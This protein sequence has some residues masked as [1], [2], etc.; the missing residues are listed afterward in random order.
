MH[1]RRK[2]LYIDVNL[3]VKISYLC[4]NSQGASMP[5]FFFLLFLTLYNRFF[6]GFFILFF[7]P[8]M[9]AMELA[10]KHR[11]NTHLQWKSVGEMHC[12]PDVRTVDACEGRTRLWLWL[13]RARL[14]ASGFM[15]LP[16]WQ[17]IM[18]T[19]SILSIEQG[20]TSKPMKVTVHSDLIKRFKKMKWTTLQTATNRRPLF[21][22]I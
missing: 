15:T 4:E 5:Y 17:H 12:R 18:A 7:M 1:H 13:W 22:R 14:L 16:T 8:F 19:L 20:N 6:W 21:T 2:L 10:W 9:W 3:W 11:E